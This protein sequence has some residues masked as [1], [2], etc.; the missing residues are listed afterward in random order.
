[1][2][3]LEGILGQL[4]VGTEVRTLIHA[5]YALYPFPVV[6]FAGLGVF[7]TL[8]RK[9]NATTKRAIY[10]GLGFLGALLLIYLPY[11]CVDPRFMLAASF[12]VFAAAGY[13][14]ISA[15]RGLERGWAGFAVIALD[16]VLAGAIVV[17]TI[18]RIAMPLPQRSK[19]VADVL[20]WYRPP[21]AEERRGGSPTFPY[22]GI[23]ALCGRRRTGVC[24]PP[25]IFTPHKCPTRW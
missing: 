17:Q 24:R 9:G 19:L 12:I 3:G 5:R 15:N 22:N 8:R 23:R 16:V 13:G 1:M 4:T 6:I 14:L 20:G 2:L 25:I 11:F 21:A 10:L 7:F 18:S